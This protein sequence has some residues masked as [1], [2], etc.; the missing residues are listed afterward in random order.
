VDENSKEDQNRKSGLAYSA[1]LALFVSVAV[2]GGI[3]LAI[4]RS[5]V[6][7]PWFTV[8]GI[9]IGTAVGFYEFFKITSRL[10]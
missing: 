10:S 8:G 7:T 5:F 3:G 6:L 2:F 4:D 9:V 1:G